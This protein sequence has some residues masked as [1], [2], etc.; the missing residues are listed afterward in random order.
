MEDVFGNRIVL[1]EQDNVQTYKI[2]MGR[3]L[4]AVAFFMSD[5]PEKWLKNVWVSDRSSIGDFG[6]E[7][8]DVFRI[9][10]TLDVPVAQDDYLC[11]IA[12]RIHERVSDGVD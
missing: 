6:L 7:D 11:S 12:K 9:A 2:E 8:E 3:V 5:D 4:A 1:A 10:E